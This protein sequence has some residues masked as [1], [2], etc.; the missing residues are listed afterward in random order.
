MGV[1]MWL[2]YGQPLHAWAA[3]ALIGVAVFL[4]MALPSISAAANWIDRHSA[5]LTG[6]LVVGRLA[7]FATQVCLNLVL[8]GA[9]LSGGVVVSANV[10]QVGGLVS[11]AALTTGASQGLQLVGLWLA[12]RRLGTVTGNV[13]A[14]LSVNIVVT[15]L[16][17][18]GV[19][20][21]RTVSL[22]LG[23]GLALVMITR[24]LKDEPRFRSA[25]KAVR[26]K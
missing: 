11:A 18:A 13:I 15:A 6:M 22:A 5:Q 21:A 8:F 20:W 12:E 9:L 25:A 19:D 23:I 17:I 4:G 16:A 10:A 2:A 14:A 7:Q 26:S 24:D 3:P 1:I